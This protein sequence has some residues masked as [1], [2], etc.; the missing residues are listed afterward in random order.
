LGNQNQGVSG[1]KALQVLLKFFPR[2]A[3]SLTDIKNNKDI[4]G[5]PF[6]DCGKDFYLSRPISQKDFLVWFYQ[7]SRLNDNDKISNEQPDALYRRL[8][9]QA[10]N[11]NWL[12]GSAITYRVMQEFLYRYEVSRKLNYE[13]YSD[14]L[15]LN[16][17]EINIRNF[18]NVYDVMEYENGIFK[19][20][21]EIKAL[22]TRSKNQNDLLENLNE[23]YQAY[24]D[25]ETEILIRRHPINVINS[26][27]GDIKDN[28]VKYGMNEV[29]DQISYDYSKNI[30][31]R[32]YNLIYGLSKISGKIW[33]P[34]DV[35][36]LMEILSDKNWGDYKWGWVLLGGNEE[37]QLGGGLC[38]VATMLFTPAWRSGL[39][40]IKRFPHSSY[41]KS[42][43]PAESIGLDATIYRNSRKNLKIR[44]NSEKPIMY[45]VSDNKE[46]QV[47]TVYLI[48]SSPYRDIRIEGP[49]QKTKN[50]Y[51]WFRHMESLD[52]TI[53]IEELATQYRAVY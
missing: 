53:N 6:L 25:L 2:A 12:S 11:M 31:N 4:C 46:N 41:Y 5:L 10:R 40:I 28:I 30:S 18:N 26:L 21:L 1:G 42:L 3:D 13:P 45:Y 19:R 47:A 15:V 7:L 29:L 20:I 51:K 14:A 24:R 34:G 38:G 37:W 17:D 22:K 32:K 8:W 9:L 44:N 49:V 16:T 50:A 52:G 27:P 23:Y 36:D 35:M 43:Y 48:G 33:M 39:Q